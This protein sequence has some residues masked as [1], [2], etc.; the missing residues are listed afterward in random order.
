TRQRGRR[1]PKARA[2]ISFAAWC[3]NVFC[4]KSGFFRGGRLDRRLPFPAL[5]PLAK[6]RAFYGGRRRIHFSLML[7]CTNALLL[8]NNIAFKP[9]RPRL[10]SSRRRDRRNRTN[11]KSK[12]RVRK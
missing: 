5:S 3:S 11:T 8:C 2:S 7:Q 12:K 10:F 9:D 4:R 1:A 6:E